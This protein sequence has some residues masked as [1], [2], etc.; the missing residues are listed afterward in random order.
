[1]IETQVFKAAWSEEYQ[2]KGIPS[3]YRKNPTT[4]V[5]EFLAWLRKEDRKLGNHAADIGCGLGRNSFYLASEGFHVT[6]L[7]LIDENVSLVNEY[8]RLHHLPIEAFAQDVSGK[9]PIEESS[10]DITLDIFCYK[11]LINK[12]LQKSYRKELFRTLKPGGLFFISLASVTD[13]YY[14]SLLE[15]SENFLEKQVVD[16]Q[17]NIPSFLYSQE[18]LIEELSDHLEVVKVSE[19]ASISPMYGKEYS[20]KVINAIFKKRTSK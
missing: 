9:W 16:P 14:G 18:S 5:V 13:G 7:E 4:V 10:L 12:E 11:H 2:K 1:M 19:D 6:S 20:R 17:S 15:H 3:S 8:A